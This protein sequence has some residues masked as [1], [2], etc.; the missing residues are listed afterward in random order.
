MSD[1][2]HLLYLYRKLINKNRDF[3]RYNKKLKV[4]NENLKKEIEST[5]GISMIVADQRDKALEDCLRLTRCIAEL[6]DE[7][8]HFQMNCPDVVGTYEPSE[9]DEETKLPAKELCERG[10]Y[11][12]DKYIDVCEDELSEMVYYRKY[13][14]HV[15]NCDVCKA[16][17]EQIK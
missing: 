2:N 11:L 10:K 12:A 16:A 7:L 13:N 8:M 9:S 6:E 14:E 15:V 1:Y 5:K 4:E 3:Y 17:L